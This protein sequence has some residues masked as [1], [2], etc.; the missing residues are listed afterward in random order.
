MIAPPASQRVRRSMSSP[1]ACGR[2]RRA[3]HSDAPLELSLLLLLTSP[4]Q[5]NQSRHDDH[6]APPSRERVVVSDCAAGFAARAPIYV[7]ALRVRPQP[8]RRAR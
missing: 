4:R 8:P 3:E 7:R 2:S 5:I 6:K 1:R